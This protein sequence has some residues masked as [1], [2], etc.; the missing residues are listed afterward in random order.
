MKNQLQ[1]FWQEWN[2]R[3]FAILILHAESDDNNMWLGL[4]M[5]GFHTQ[6]Q[7]F[8]NTEFNY[9]KYYNSGREADACIK[10]ATIL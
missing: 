8:R 6:L 2:M 10:F 3:M 1:P 5:P 4:R 9:V 7:I